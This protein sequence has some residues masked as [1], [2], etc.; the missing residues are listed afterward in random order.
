M[1]KEVNF[2]PRVTAKC[3]TE[4]CMTLVAKWG[5][6]NKRDLGCYKKEEET[7]FIRTMDKLA[8]VVKV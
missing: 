5:K 8:V 2:E 4:K 7:A 3:S 1:N 6:R